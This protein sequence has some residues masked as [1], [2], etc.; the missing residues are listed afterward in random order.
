MKAFLR[1]FSKVLSIF[2]VIAMLAISY[3]DN[4]KQVTFLTIYMI[5]NG[6][7]NKH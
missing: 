4:F 5:A 2:I 1:A 6:L 3:V 7:R